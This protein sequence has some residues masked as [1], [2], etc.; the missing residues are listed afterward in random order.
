MKGLE[1]A[2]KSLPPPPPPASVPVA[3]APPAGVTESKQP[4]GDD[5]PTAPGIVAVGNLKGKKKMQAAASASATQAPKPTTVAGAPVTPAAKLAATL[6]PFKPAL[7]Q[8]GKPAVVTNAR[9]KGKG[10]H[11]VTAS[12]ALGAPPPPPAG[13]TGASITPSKGAVARSDTHDKPASAGEGVWIEVTPH[14]RRNRRKAAT[15]D[16]GSSVDIEAGFA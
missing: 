16:T 10:T 2:L 15:P 4:E 14:K 7:A 8:A 9:A 12:G 3:A 5:N 1:G 6:S 13:S 11:T